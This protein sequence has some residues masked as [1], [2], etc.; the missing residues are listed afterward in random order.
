VPVSTP[1]GDGEG[2]VEDNGGYT[3]KRTEP[4]RTATA[5]VS[6][7]STRG[8]RRCRAGVYTGREEEGIA[9]E[10]TKGTERVNQKGSYEEEQDTGILTIKGPAREE[11][12]V[13]NAHLDT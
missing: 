13:L 6:S 12:K 4:L 8:G 11:K 1:A 7:A 3:E 5:T 10:G 2:T 9:T